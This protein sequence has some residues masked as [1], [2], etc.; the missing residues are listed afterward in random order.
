MTGSLGMLALAALSFLGLHALSSVRPLRGAIVGAIGE[1]L[2]RGLFSLVAAAAMVWLVR[3]YGEAPVGEPLWASGPLTRV[4]AAILMI[5][6]WLLFVGGVTTANP[7]AVG[8]EGVLGRDDPA[9]GFVRITRHPLLWSFGL[10]GIAHLL[11][12]NDPAALILFGSLTALALGGTVLIDRKKAA[13]GEDWRRFAARTSNL[14]FAAVLGGRNRIVWR[15][16][17]WWR[18]GLGLGLFVA[19]VL[20]HETVIGVSPRPF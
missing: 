18:I 4:L 13:A 14:P 6:A 1:G 8:G 9:R 17:G 19:A 11:N 20:L 15:E 7:T 2:Y 10:W 12:R 5:P 16:I 3:A